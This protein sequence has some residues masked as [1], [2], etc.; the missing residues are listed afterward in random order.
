MTGS[1]R[2]SG[3]KQLGRAVQNLRLTIEIGCARDV[4]FDEHERLEAIEVPQ[5]G[6]Q[7]AQHVERRN[8]SCVPALLKGEL[9]ADLPAVLECAVDERQL[10]RDIQHRPRLHD[11]FISARGARGLGQFESEAGE[12][13]ENRTL[14]AHENLVL[15]R[16]RRSSTL[17]HARPMAD[18]PHSPIRDMAMTNIRR[19]DLNLLVALDVLLEERNVSRAAE[20]LA[21]TQPTVSGMLRRLRA[22][23]GDELLVRTQRGMLPTARAESLI[24]P[25]KRLLA[26]AE[27]VV[28]PPR[29]DP[30]TTDRQFTISTTDY[31]QYALVIPLIAQ[32]RRVAPHARIAARPLESA[33]L[34][35]RLASGQID[36][37]ITAPAWAPAGLRSR[38]LYK[39][40]YVCVM[41][42]HHPLAREK[43]TER[44]FTQA[45][46][47]VF[48]PLQGGFT[49]DADAALARRGLSRSVRVSLSN[50]LLA[51]TLV[52]ATDLIALVPSRMLQQPDNDLLVAEPPVSGPE[53]NV[54]AVWHPRSHAD[55]GHKWLRQL[56][57]DVARQ[58]DS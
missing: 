31:M 19:I 10:C 23:L 29:F 6:A 53:F 22:L 16:V 54:M 4:A 43:L 40:K 51:L 12:T 58:S 27:A 32:M 13:S 34:S 18:Q 41:G 45:E 55:L 36:L 56:L 11:G 21:L 35:R 14:R 42:R 5:C 52:K 15:A 47:V 24:E 46:H 38:T 25:L 33:E 7:L 2:K 17:N 8:R 1:L 3:V 50:Y 20:R 9:G 30:A 37:A 57:A 49:G 39:E 44:A 26:D 28:A 48:S